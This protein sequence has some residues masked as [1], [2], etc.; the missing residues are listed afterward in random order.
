[1]RG[2]AL[3]S[4]IFIL[5]TALGLLI[6]CGSAA[7][8]SEDTPTCYPACAD[9]QTC[10]SGLCVDIDSSLTTGGS[11]STGGSSNVA[12]SGNVAGQGAD[13]GLGGDAGVGGNSNVG[14]D[15]AGGSSDTAT[16]GDAPMATGG[17]ANASGGSGPSTGGAAPDATG[18]NAPAT[19]GQA[20]TTGGAAPLATG[21]KA[22]TGGAAPMATGGLTSTGGTT[23]CSHTGGASST[24]GQA[25]T[26]GT[27]PQ[28]SCDLP[29][30][31]GQACDDYL[32]VPVP[33]P[34]GEDTSG[35]AVICHIPPGNP[36]NAHTIHVGTA[37]VPAHLAH[38]DCLGE[39]GNCCPAST[40]QWW[41]GSVTTATLPIY[42]N[43][44]CFLSDLK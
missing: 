17:D 11:G 34:C 9:G 20:P 32:C 7:T 10:Q 16:G 26:G 39:C 44:A 29:C 14:G 15:N 8:Y 30:P 13:N 36:G 41:T 27:G 42:L 2:L 40:P 22:P 4:T 35:K 19:G 1:M 6:G 38:G 31:T 28:C 43:M 23:G 21:G 37:A 18:G 3:S 12:G 5:G 25:G 33:T 24:G